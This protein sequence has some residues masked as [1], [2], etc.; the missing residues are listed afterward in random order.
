MRSV[1]GGPVHRMGT[2]ETLPPV[3]P[4]EL[5]ADRTIVTLEA[6]R[7]RCDTVE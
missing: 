3:A 2:G 5:G 4:N 7:I 6:S 1:T